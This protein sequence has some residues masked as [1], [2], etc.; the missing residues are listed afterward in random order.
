MAYNCMYSFGIHA[1]CFEVLG[2]L[3][4]GRKDYELP[5]T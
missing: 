5:G 1:I 4:K 3:Q 2:L